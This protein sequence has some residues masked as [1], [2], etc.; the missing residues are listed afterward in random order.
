MERLK[1]ARVDSHYN[2]YAIIPS[3]RNNFI[4]RQ[5][6]RV[7]ADLDFGF[8]TIQYSPDNSRNY[9]YM[10]RELSGG[11]AVFSVG[12]GANYFFNDK[13]GLELLLPFIHTKNITSNSVNTIYSGIGPT[14]GF[15]YTL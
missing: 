8:G 4:N 3:V 1:V 13:F 12:L 5:K 15:V 2:S 6:L 14:I 7:F 9:N 10:H 11:I